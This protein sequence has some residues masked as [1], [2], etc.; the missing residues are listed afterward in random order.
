MKDKHDSILLKIMFVV[1]M[2]GWVAVVWISYQ[3]NGI[4]TARV[5]SGIVIMS[6]GTF[7]YGIFV[8]GV[9]EKLRLKRIV[10]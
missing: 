6:L 4:L 10:Q 2:V 3:A 1:I 8:G 9:L 5:I 7:G